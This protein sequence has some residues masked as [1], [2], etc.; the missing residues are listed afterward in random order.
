MPFDGFAKTYRR[1]GVLATIH[2]VIISIINRFIKLR[3]LVIYVKQTSSPL[4]PC[5]NDILIRPLSTHE[6][7][8][9]A[10][11]PGLELPDYFIDEAIANGDECFGAFT[12]N[13]LSAY[14]W[15]ATRPSKSADETI[16]IFNADYVYTYKDLT[17][18]SQR[19]RSLQKFIK[20]F[21]LEHYHQQGKR[22]IIVGIDS[23]NFSSRASIEGSGALKVGYCTYIKRG[24]YLINLRSNGAKRFGF[25]LINTPDV[26]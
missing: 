4:K 26:V 15:Y 19:G 16:A 14:G 9:I 8:A 25:K 18:P 13:E 21:T 22:G 2:D 6:L 20:E 3:V 23:I 7:K 1:F 11:T 12:Q 5:P 24:K 10:D 17:L